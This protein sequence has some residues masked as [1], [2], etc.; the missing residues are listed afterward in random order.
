[1]FS[2]RHVK[3]NVSTF[4]NFTNFLIIEEY[5]ISIILSNKSRLAVYV[6]RRLN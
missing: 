6:N 4:F 3:L 1:M 2:S 5:S